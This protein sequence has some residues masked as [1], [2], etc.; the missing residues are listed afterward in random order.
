MRA[1]VMLYEMSY[2][3]RHNPICTSRISPQLI[4]IKHTTLKKS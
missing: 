1:C 2:L 3:A 4:A